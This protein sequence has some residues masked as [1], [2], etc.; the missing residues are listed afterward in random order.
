MGVPPPPGL[1]SHYQLPREGVGWSDTNPFIAR[2]MTIVWSWRLNF[3]PTTAPCISTCF[4]PKVIYLSNL[5]LNCLHQINDSYK[6]ASGQSIS[7]KQVNKSIDIILWFKGS[8]VNAIKKRHFKKIVWQNVPLSYCSWKIGVFVIISESKW[9]HLS[10]GINMTADLTQRL[11]IFPCV[12]PSLV[13]V[14]FIEHA[15]LV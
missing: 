11:Q 10:L 4:H 14:T 5:P 6:L 3:S 15:W 13:I 2:S 8:F 12:H 7:K 1:W 9:S